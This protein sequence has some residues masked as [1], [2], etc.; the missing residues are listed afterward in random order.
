MKLCTIPDN[1]G[2]RQRND[3]TLLSC[4]A[5]ENGNGNLAQLRN[6]EPLPV[7]LSNLKNQLYQF[8]ILKRAVNALDVIE[9][10][11]DKRRKLGESKAVLLDIR[12]KLAQDDSLSDQALKP[13]AER[14]YPHI[15]EWAYIPSSDELAKEADKQINLLYSENNQAVKAIAQQRMSITEI[16]KDPCLASSSDDSSTRIVSDDQIRI[17]YSDK[18]DT[19]RNLFKQLDLNIVGY[20]G[21][22]ADDFL[23]DF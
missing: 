4:L 13:I 19:C 12:E 2:T 20:L 7:I 21:Y 1:P 22:A 18:R 9:K 6:N 5:E 3:E 23:K 17:W 15:S 16:F 10:L 8:S 14:L 11:E